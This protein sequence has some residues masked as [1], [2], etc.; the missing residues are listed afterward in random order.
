MQKNHFQFLEELYHICL[1]FNLHI[2]L[3]D[4][5]G[6][7]NFKFIGSSKQLI[8]KG[9]VMSKHVVIHKLVALINI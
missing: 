5:R 6:G 4:S 2:S 3:T 1:E 7:F 8:F 9:A